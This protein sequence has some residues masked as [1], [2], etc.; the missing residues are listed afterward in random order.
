MWKYVIFFSTASI[1]VCHAKTLSN[2]DKVERPEEL[3]SE[4]TF[5][6]DMK[7]TLEQRTQIE[8]QIEA[9]T[10]RLETRKAHADLS[11]RWEDGIVPYRIEPE[12]AGDTDVIL[13]AIEHWESKTSLRFPQYNA[14][15]HTSFI[16]FT[17]QDGCWSYVGHVFT[18]AQEISIGNG[19]AYMGT[20]AHEIGHAI[21]FFHEQSRPDRD[22]YVVINEEN[23]IPGY[24]RNFQKYDT[25]TINTYQVPYDIGSLMHYGATYFTSNGLNTIDAVNPDDQGLMGQRTGLSAADILLANTMYASPG[26]SYYFCFQH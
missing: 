21:G 1:F 15:E 12:S 23:I 4:G 16:S 7:L 8:K 17:K 6:S 26:G 14:D 22:E 19:C 18:G 25:G 13:S 24:E 5:E 2:V 11:T 3:E 9:Q 20:I 10:N